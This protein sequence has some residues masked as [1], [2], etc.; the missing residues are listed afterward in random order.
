[1]FENVKLHTDWLNEQIDQLTIYRNTIQEIFQRNLHENYADDAE[2]ETVG[3]LYQDYFSHA[4]K[5]RRQVLF[6]Q[7]TSERLVKPKQ[8]K[9]TLRRLDEEDGREAKIRKLMDEASGAAAPVKELK[10]IDAAS[11]SFAA[12]AAAAASDREP[13]ASIPQPPTPMRPPINFNFKELIRE[14]HNIADRPHAPH[15]EITL[16]MEEARRLDE[17]LDKQ[18]KALNLMTRE[19]DQFNRV[20]NKRVMFYRFLQ[21]LSDDVRIPV[22]IAEPDEKFRELDMLNETFNVQFN[23]EKGRLRYLTNIM[24]GMK[25]VSANAGSALEI[26][27]SEEG[28]EEEDY[29]CQICRGDY[30]QAE[31]AIVTVCGVCFNDIFQLYTFPQPTHYSTCIALFASRCG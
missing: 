16:C 26:N 22:D 10:T 3:Y 9:S 30:R 6:G 7:Q 31:K 5:L 21:R 11:T 29:L 18:S 15:G 19:C 1:M 14:L 12:A 13:E 28:E 20:W 17:I 23:T 24:D 4:L 27:T 2:A 25:A 8:R